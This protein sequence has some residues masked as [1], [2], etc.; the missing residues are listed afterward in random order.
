[1]T[2]LLLSV[3]VT[4]H[5]EPPAIAAHTPSHPAL[6]YQA[7][8]YKLGLWTSRLGQQQPDTALKAGRAGLGRPAQSG[9]GDGQ[10]VQDQLDIGVEI[11]L[12]FGGSNVLDRVGGGFQRDR[13]GGL[14]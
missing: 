14:L 9:K 3:E 11:E 13:R 10:R 4:S 8:W 6:P 7:P 2:V 1:M 5:D 12:T